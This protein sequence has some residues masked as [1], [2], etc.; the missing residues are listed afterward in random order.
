MSN[1]ATL[2]KNLPSAK[3]TDED[4]IQQILERLDKLSKRPEDPG[5]AYRNLE[6]INALV[7][8]LRD[9]LDNGTEN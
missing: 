5:M 3:Q 7:L 6:M 1:V 9:K 2:K 8:N 4:N